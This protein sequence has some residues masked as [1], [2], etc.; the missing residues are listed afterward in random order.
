M[1]LGDGE[2]EVRVEHCVVVVDDEPGILE[3]LCDVLEMEGYATACVE[4]PAEAQC[5]TA[6]QQ[7][8]LFLI[9]LMLPDMD[10]IELARHLRQ[11][12]CQGVPMIAMSASGEMIQAAKRSGL[13]QDT[14]AKP[15]D[16]DRVLYAVE[17]FIQ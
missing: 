11:H 9:D 16:I 12:G 3:T 15:F 2:G 7:P 17:Q 5:D 4:H 1:A 13:F 8:H 6:V 14:I 10:G